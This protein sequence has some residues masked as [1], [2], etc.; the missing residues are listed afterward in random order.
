MSKTV[1]KFMPDDIWH[2]GRSESWFSDMAKN[3][4]HLRKVG[5]KQD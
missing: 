2:L 1:R 3:G 5:Y 4:L